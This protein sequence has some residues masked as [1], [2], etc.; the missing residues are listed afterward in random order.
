MALK[1]GVIASGE[2]QGWSIKIIDDT[3]GDTGGFYL[4]LRDPTNIEVFDYWFEKEEFLKNQLVDFDVCWD[5]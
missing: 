1:N 5:F 4:I 3:Q 2:Y